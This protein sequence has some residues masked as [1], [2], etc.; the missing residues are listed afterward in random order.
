VLYQ[1]LEDIAVNG[2]YAFVKR[3]ERELLPF[4][5]SW[6]WWKELY[7]DLVRN[8]VPI[9]MVKGG[10]SKFDAKLVDD[11]L[12]ERRK[13][14][15]KEEGGRKEDQSELLTTKPKAR[16]RE[17]ATTVLRKLWGNREHTVEK[18]LTN[19]N[20]INDAELPCVEIND[21]TSFKDDDDYFDDEEDDRILL[22]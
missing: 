1:H 6:E 4:P 20:A 22:V 16:F 5:T 11:I 7:A 3:V 8:E 9:F 13:R 18:P 19:D 17:S 14:Q 21:S 15:R 10:P 2:D 12:S